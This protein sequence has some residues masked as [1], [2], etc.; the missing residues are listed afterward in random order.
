M[1]TVST[2]Y[3]LVSAFWRHVVNYGCHLGARW[4][5]EGS[6]NRTFPHKINKKYE[7]VGTR[8]GA[9]KTWNY[10]GE[11]IQKGGTLLGKRKA[12]AWYV[13]WSKKFR[14]S[15]QLMEHVCQNGSESHQNRCIG[16]PRLHWFRSPPRFAIF[17][18]LK[19]L[20]KSKRYFDVFWRFSKLISI[21]VSA[22]RCNWFFAVGSAIF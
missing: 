8:S 16:R 19:S 9:P 20:E 2:G 12:F 21:S 1:Q 10:E 7:K 18:F 22:V 14:W 15:S 4:I 5:L 17:E 13:L 3:Y 11:S 6:P